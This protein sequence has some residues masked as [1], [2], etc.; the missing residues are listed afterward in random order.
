M[1]HGKNNRPHAKVVGFLRLCRSDVRRKFINMILLCGIPSE[2]PI[3]LVRERLEAAHLPYVMFSQRRFAEMDLEFEISGNQ[4]RG[5]LRIGEATHR[6]E[7]FTGVYTRLMDDQHLPELQ[8]E[9]PGSR[10]RRHARGLHDALLRWSEITPALVVNR[11]TPMGSN[12]SKPFQAQM[13]L[14][15]G[16]R[17]PETLITN[18][19]DLVRD[20]HHRH[21]RIIYKSMSGVRSI[22][23]TFEE[24]DYDRLHHIRWCPTQFQ[25]YVEGTNIRV[26]TLGAEVFATAIKTDATDY[27]YARK[28]IG[29]YAELEATCLDD[30]TAERCIQL[31]RVLE[32]PFA[33]IDLKV[34]P[35]GEVYCF[36]VNPSPAYS[37]YESNTGQSISHALARMLANPPN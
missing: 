20:F 33:G 32:L 36:E 19:P 17:T 24:K 28:Q 25:A 35:D 26:H 10:S 12:F 3:A 13:I 9:P 31:A 8:S 22:V 27:R 23:Q 29:D 11:A 18:D 30:D 37:Y 5:F 15:A 14:R 4:V 2:S 34:T 21:G 16:F 7:E 1:K 6:L